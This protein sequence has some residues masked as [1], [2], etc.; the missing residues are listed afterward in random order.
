MTFDNMVVV[1]MHPVENMRRTAEKHLR[2]EGL[3]DRE[4][5]CLSVRVLQDFFVTVTR[6]VPRPLSILGPIVTANW[7]AD[8]GEQPVVPL[9]GGVGRVFR[10]GRRQISASAQARVRYI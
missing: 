4:T 2:L 8:T 1:F 5:G 9:G 3:W 6:K 7:K 10:V